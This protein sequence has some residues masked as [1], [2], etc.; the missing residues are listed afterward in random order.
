MQGLA[1]SSKLTTM[2]I[3]LT[4]LLIGLAGAAHGRRRIVSNDRTS[5]ARR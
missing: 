4:V 1:A 5:R 3:V 2:A